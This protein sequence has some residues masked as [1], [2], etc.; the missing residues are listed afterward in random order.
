MLMSGSRQRPKN[1]QSSYLTYLPHL[2]N[3]TPELINSGG[4]VS[5][6]C[7]SVI[8]HSPAACP[9]VRYHQSIIIVKNNLNNVTS[10]DQTRVGIPHY[11]NFFCNKLK[12]LK[13]VKNLKLHR[14]SGELA[15]DL[16]LRKPAGYWYDAA[17]SRRNLCSVSSLLFGLVTV[18]VTTKNRFCRRLF[19][20][21]FKVSVS[22]QSASEG[23]T[24]LLS[25]LTD[26]PPLVINTPAL[27]SWSF[28]WS[29]YSHNIPDSIQ[30]TVN[31]RCHIPE[32]K[33]VCG[34]WLCF[35]LVYPE[36]VLH[37]LV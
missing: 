14:R 18:R 31:T 24:D 10:L 26:C 3:H 29:H 2:H 1:W 6:F 16:S 33:H 21:Y 36:A 34:K 13:Q 23:L 8:R 7:R 19:R 12:L 17:R 5:K 30:A 32:F 20:Q 4:R 37:C 35:F 22:R 25:V 15:T 27:N 28:P 11:R 9:P